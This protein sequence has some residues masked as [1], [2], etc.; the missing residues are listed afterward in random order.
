MAL[1]VAFSPDGSRVAA[2]GADRTI[3]IFDAKSGKQTRL[4]RNHA[5]WVE[6]VAFSPD[7][8]HVLSASRDRTVRISD[9][10]N[11]ELEATNTSHETAIYAAIFSHDGKTVL[12]LAQNSP[13]DYWQWT[14]TEKKPRQMELA[15]HPDHLAWVTGGLALAGP[16]SLVRIASTSNETLFTLYGHP[17]AISALAVGPTSD[18]LATGSY[19]GTVCVWNLACGTWVRRFIASP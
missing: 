5:D 10:L 14:T 7:G 2:G 11:G 6:S 19:D 17:D 18:Q 13:L 4:L 1:C 8:V 3:R 16:D 9:P 12:S 15:G